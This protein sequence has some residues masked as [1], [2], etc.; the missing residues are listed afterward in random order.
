[1]RTFLALT[2]QIGG[3]LRRIFEAGVEPMA[4]S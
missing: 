1:M 4:L 3:H 2:Y